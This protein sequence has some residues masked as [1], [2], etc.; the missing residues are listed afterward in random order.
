MTTS[1][2]RK[3]LGGPK[4]VPTSCTRRKV[5]LPLLS[6]KSARAGVVLAASHNV[7]IAAIMNRRM[8]PPRSVGLGHPDDPPV[9]NTGTEVV[10]QHVAIGAKGG[11]Q[12]I[13]HAVACVLF[14]VGA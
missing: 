2:S 14:G 4:P 6:S 13:E 12:D 3:S 8:V 11:P 10:D 9:S 1:T 7:R 5:I